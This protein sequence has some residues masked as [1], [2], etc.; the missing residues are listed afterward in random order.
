MANIEKEFQE[1][2][3]LMAS[4]DCSG[5]VKKFNKIIKADPSCAEAYFGKA[6]AAL[7][8]PNISD[9]ETIACYKKAIELDGNNPIYWSGYA[10]FLIERGKFNDAESAYNRAAEVD[11]DNAKYYYSEFGV[12]YASRAPIVMEKF[13]DEKTKEI[14][15]KK[16]LKYLLKSIGLSEE[17][18]KKL[19]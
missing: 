12:E 5:A 10:S 2:R 14:I 6:E 7:S 18:A 11:L 13:L 1:A 9:D 19:L 4:G 16:A 3:D 17:E 8:E 15:Q